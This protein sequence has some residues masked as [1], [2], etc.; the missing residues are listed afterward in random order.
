MRCVTVE[1]ALVVVGLVLLALGVVVLAREMV[2]WAMGHANKDLAQK[3]GEL[4]A[5]LAEEAKARR[6]LDDLLRG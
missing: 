4:Q 2:K 5:Q 3:T 6:A 1:G